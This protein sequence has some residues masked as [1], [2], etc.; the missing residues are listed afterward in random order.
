MTAPDP[1]VLAWAERMNTLPGHAVRAAVSVGLPEQLIAWSDVE[2][3]SARL[4]TDPAATR[5][6]VDYLAALGLVERDAT[7]R[8]RLSVTGQV[9]RRDHPA[10]LASS[11]TSGSIAHRM[12][13][14]LARLE[15]V[16]RTGR[17]SYPLVHGHSLYDDV[18]AEPRYVAEALSSAQGLVEHTAIGLAAWLPLPEQSTVADL[19]CGSGTHLLH[20]L[21]AHPTVSGVAV[22]L[23]GTLEGAAARW[24][25]AD[26]GVRERVTPCPGSFLS[27]PLPVAQT[28]LLSNVLVDLDDP[29]AHRLLQRVV[30]AAPDGAQV[31][32]VELAADD[33]DPAFV[34]HLGLHQMCMTG[35]R[36]R[37]VAEL[38]SLAAGAGLD[39]RDTAALGGG[40]S[41]LRLEIGA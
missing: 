26:P 5:Q 16:L 41:A 1:A 35:G 30:S 38:G 24:A 27:D 21:A 34:S 25:T 4:T 14:A 13:G 18:D 3:A 31:V 32:V 40:I 9:L 22:D 11:W 19:G 39:A 15:D 29:T 17:P 28:Y 23:P 6:L 10:G 37:T 33:A 20:L 8:A 12:E 2:T 7:G 36:V